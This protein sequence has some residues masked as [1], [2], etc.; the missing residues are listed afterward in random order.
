MNSMPINSQQSFLPTTL[1]LPDV[2]QKDEFNYVLTDFIKKM[3]AAINEREVAQYPFDEIQ[4]GQKFS[5]RRE[6]TQQIST[7]RKVIDF[8]AL[9]DNTTKTVPHQ[10]A[11]TGSTIFT[12][13][14][15]V[16]N[17]P[18]TSFIPL[19][20][21]SSVASEAIKLEITP[22]DVEITTGIDYSDYTETLVILEYFQAT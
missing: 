15:G 10:I 9:P 11:V 13:I 7:Y 8:G 17:D 19:P 1:I 21:S 16:A 18:G 20:F 12:R 6:L 2:D 5:D 3:I 14:Y 22:N 4:T